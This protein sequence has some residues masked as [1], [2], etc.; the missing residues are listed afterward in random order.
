[1]KASGTLRRY[2]TFFRALR[3]GPST[4]GAVAPSGRSLARAMVGP[5]AQATAEDVRILEVG[6]GTGV[7]TQEIVRH[8]R[9]RRHLDVVEL[10]GMFVELLQQRFANEP[11]LQ[12]VRNHVEVHHAALQ[13]F[14]AAQKAGEGYDFI[15][16]GLPL[17]NF[18]PETVSEI[19]AVL[20]GLA[21]PGGVLTYFEYMFFRAARSRLSLRADSPIRR[22]DRALNAW[23]DH[24]QSSREAVWL[25][26]LPAWVHCVRF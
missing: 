10:E 16:S 5:L 23:Q 24:H 21:K 11:A 14:A 8:L 15:I 1:M 12:A 7:F 9:G 26:V 2:G 3:R 6:P 4:V 17:N 18:S 20:E 25:N 19:L 22:L 13:E